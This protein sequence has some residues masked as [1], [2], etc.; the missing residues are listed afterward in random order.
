MAVIIKTKNLKWLKDL[1]A[2]T[3]QVIALMAKGAALKKNPDGGFTLFVGNDSWTLVNATGGP[4]TAEEVQA[5]L[6]TSVMPDVLSKGKAVVDATK[7][8]PPEAEAPVPEVVP[9][10]N[11]K[12]LYQRVQ[13]TSNGSVYVVVGVADHGKLKLAAKVEG[14]TS[15]SL[16]VRAEGESLSSVFVVSAL[17]SQGLS[18]KKKDDI[19]YMSAHYVCTDEAPPAKVLGAIML[20]SGLEFKTPLPSMDKV[21]EGSV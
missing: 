13:G 2:T 4:I 15:M 1:G 12:A 3:A 9:L 7:L 8:V 17:K 20:G 19:Q 18:L 16:S 10:R 6:D 21:K 11:A 14:P 5:Y